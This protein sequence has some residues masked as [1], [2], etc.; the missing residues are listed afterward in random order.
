MLG[1]VALGLVGLLIWAGMAV[2]S[3]L[4]AEAPAL[5]EAGKRL[6]G[7]PITQVEQ[8]ASSLKEQV[9]QWTPGVKEQVDRW[10]PQPARES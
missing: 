1:A 8:L 5:T 2:L 4:W 6:A 3:W 9:E 10:K 7:E